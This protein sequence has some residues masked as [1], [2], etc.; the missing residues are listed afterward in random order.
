MAITFV[1]REYKRFAFIKRIAKSDIEKI[2]IP[3]GPDH[4]GEAGMNL[5]SLTEIIENSEINAQY[6]QMAN[7]LL[8]DRDTALSAVLQ[9]FYPIS[10]TMTS[11]A[12]SPHQRTRGTGGGWDDPSL[13]RSWSA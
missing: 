6:P 11:T 3:G 8:H 7:T 13:H 1:T 2:A 4:Q 12:R 5:A 9:H 10:W